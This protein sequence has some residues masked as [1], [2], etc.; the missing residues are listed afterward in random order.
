MLREDHTYTFQTLF[1]CQLYKSTCET[2]IWKLK[3]A[4]CIKMWVKGTFLFFLLYYSSQS[5]VFVTWSKAHKVRPLTTLQ[6]ILQTFLY[7]SAIF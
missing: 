2:Y 7:L 5:I 3:P 1:P 6:L 4:A